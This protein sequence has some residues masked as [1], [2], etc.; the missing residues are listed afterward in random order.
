MGSIPGSGRTRGEGNGYTLQSSCLESPMDRG[1]RRA[2]VHTVAKSWT[3][4]STYSLLV[5]LQF[6]VN[7]KGTQPYVYMHPKPQTLSHPGWHITL[8]RVPCAMQQ[9]TKLIYCMIF[10]NVKY[11]EYQVHKDR[12]QISGCQG[13][14]GEVNGE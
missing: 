7:N 3:Q 12:Q 13:M 5:L 2:T 4:L 11:P 1:A 9:V 10:L 8:S 6:Q 14:D